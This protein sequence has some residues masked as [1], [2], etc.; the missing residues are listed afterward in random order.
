[1]DWIT[2]QIAIGGYQDAQDPDVL[3]AKAINSILGLTRTLQ[4]AN[5]ALLGVKLV[6]VVPL[7]DGPGNEVRLFLETVDTLSRLVQ[8]APPVLV[9]CHAGRSRSVVVVAGY[10]MKSLG[11]GAN[12]ALDRVAARREVAVAPGLERLLDFIA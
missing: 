12:E 11:I 2:D 3:Q 6:E 5:P 10:L 9:H 8:E 4:G 7:E 1:M